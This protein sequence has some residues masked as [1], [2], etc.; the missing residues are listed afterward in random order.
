MGAGVGGKGGKAG[1][2]VLVYD[3]GKTSTITLA[4]P[5]AVCQYE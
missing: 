1:A 4:K 5:T 3:E 2:I